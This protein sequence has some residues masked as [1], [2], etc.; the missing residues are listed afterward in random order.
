MKDKTL[1][2]KLIHIQ[3]NLKVKKE[4]V[5]MFAKFNYRSLDDIFEAVKP[6]LIETGC[7]IRTSD[8][9]ISENGLN[10][11]SATVYLSDGKETISATSNARESISKK[12]M[13]DPQMTGTA[14][15]YARKYACNGLL[16]IDDTEDVDSMDNRAET[17]INGKLPKAGH[18]TV[19]QNIKLERQ[20][21]DPKFKDTDMQRQVRDFIDTNPTKEEADEKILKLNNMIRSK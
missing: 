3:S 1:H 12:G 16:A 9:I 2:E 17:L 6:L 19:D 18:I 10:Y 20:S 13:D 8:E 7:T 5:N 4:R 11:V 21:R 15:S 14:S